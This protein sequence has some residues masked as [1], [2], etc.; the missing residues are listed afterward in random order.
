[1][2]EQESAE[3]RR[4]LLRSV[5]ELETK[6]LNYLLVA[7]G[8]GLAGCLATLKDYATV[9]QLQGIGTPIAIF[10]AGLISAAV[11]F[12]FFQLSNFELMKK[13]TVGDDEPTRGKFLIFIMNQAMSFSGACFIFAIL[14]ISRKLASL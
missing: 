10:S 3:M 13:V 14:L 8:A 6:A 5:L 9:P 1:M 2:D 7:N 12:F 11:A 4:Q